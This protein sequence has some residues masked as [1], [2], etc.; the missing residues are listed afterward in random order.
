VPAKI[1]GDYVLV[2]DN[3][4]SMFTSKSVGL[5]YCIDRGRPFAP[6]PGAPPGSPPIP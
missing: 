4:Y 5:Y 2:F 3:R 6:G 1:N